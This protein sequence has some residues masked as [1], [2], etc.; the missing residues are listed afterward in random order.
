L[1][2]TL[3]DMKAKLLYF[4]SK[5]SYIPNNNNNNNNNSNNNEIKIVQQGE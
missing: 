1:L 2:N 4:W 5:R 3:W